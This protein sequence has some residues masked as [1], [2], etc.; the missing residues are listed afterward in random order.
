MPSTRSWGMQFPGRS[1]LDEVCRLW[2][3][4]DHEATQQHKSGHGHHGLCRA[5]ADNVFFWFLERFDKVVYWCLLSIRFIFMILPCHF[6]WLDEVG[7]TS[8]CHTC[9][10]CCRSESMERSPMPSST[11]ARAMSPASMSTW[12]LSAKSIRCFRG[13]VN[14][15]MDQHGI[16]KIGVG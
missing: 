5:L 15:K 16:K 4:R 7:W 13:A 9:H 12:M 11:K 14:P 6:W 10:T 1:S 2:G 3:A 8:S